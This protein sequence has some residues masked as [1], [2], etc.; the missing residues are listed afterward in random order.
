MNLLISTFHN[1]MC[2]KNG[3][4]LQDIKKIKD[5]EYKFQKLFLLKDL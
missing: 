4:S 3:S 1:I 5:F 2:S